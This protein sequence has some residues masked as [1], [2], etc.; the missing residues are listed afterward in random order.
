MA[1]QPQDL[2]SRQVAD[3][4]SGN[5]GTIHVDELRH[6]I[7]LWE[8]APHASLQPELGIPAN[9]SSPTNETRGKDELPNQGTT[10]DLFT[11]MKHMFTNAPATDIDNLPEPVKT[12][13]QSSRQWKWERS[14]G[15]ETTACWTSLFPKDDAQD[16]SF[17]FWC[18][19]DAAYQLNDVFGVRLAI[20]S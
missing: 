14:E 11:E 18:G 4:D 5:A 7:L 20:S 15:L 2:D 3:A 12:A 16:A 19:T 6:S 8:D 1:G 10:D 17:S 9:T 13:V